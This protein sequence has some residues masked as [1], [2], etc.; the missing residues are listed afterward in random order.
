MK[1]LEINNAASAADEFRRWAVQFAA[2][3]ERRDAP[4]LAA[5]FARDGHW[6]DLLSFTWEHRTFS[7]HGSIQ[8]AF[9][10]TLDYARP[11]NFQ[12]APTR[13]PPRFQ[14]RS[15]KEVLEGYCDFDTRFGRGTAFVRLLLTAAESSEP[16]LWLLLTTLQALTGYEERVAQRRPSGNE[17]ALNESGVSWREQRESRR[18]FADRDPEVI[19]VGAGQAGL[20]IAARLGQMGVDTMVVERHARVGDNWRERYESLTLHNEIMANHLPY[21]PFPETWPLWLSKDQVANW[22]ESYAEHLELNVWTGTTL[23][24]AGYDEGAGRWRATLRGADGRER[25]ITCRHLI[26]A[27]GAS[28]ALP[29]IPKLPGIDAFAGSVIH[30]REFRNGAEYAGKRVVVVGTGNSGHDIAQD[31]VV[32]GA[33]K[34]WLL[35]RGP[36]CVVSLT[37]TAAM[38]YKIYGEDNPT[39]DVDLMNAASPY[40]VLEDSYRFITRRGAEQDSQLLE[41]LNKAGFKTYFGSD[42]TGF[43][44]MFMRGE[45][46]YYIDVGCSKLIADGTIEVIQAEYTGSWSKEGLTMKDGSVIKCDAAIL[47]TGFKN[48]QETVRGILGDEIADKI[49]PVWGFDEHFQMR[50]MWRR[51]AQPG[52]W[53]TGGALL[54]SRLYS[55]FLAIEI[56]AQLAG[57]LPAK[58]DLPLAQAK[59]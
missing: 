56:K 40:P 7:G 24:H 23:A 36:T 22:L 13:T 41:G 44:M 45:G 37:P 38:I 33:K 35:Q 28:G 4:G 14:R 34:V 58:A 9:A 43:Q 2:A 48:M 18:A 3:L 11:A 32:K 8:A 50:N 53:L 55:R 49:G 42:G 46:G 19:V 39:E 52:L 21:L 25:Q 29:H 10:A 27:T 12:V 59:I 15:G 5:Q 16:K 20:T 51:T 54:D 1:A 31:L 26:I 30:S 17:F 47:A 6:K 57:M